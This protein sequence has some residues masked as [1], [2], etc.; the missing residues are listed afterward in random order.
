MRH[1][2]AA[3]AANWFLIVTLAAGAAAQELGKRPEQVPAPTGAPAKANSDPTYQQLRNVGL[4]GE[5]SAANNLVLKRDAGTFT[6]RSGNLYFLAPVNGKVTGAVF[7][8]E[9]SFTLVPPLRMEKNTLSLLTKEPGIT[10]EFNEL[11][12]RFTDATYEEIKKSAGVSAGSPG[13]DAGPL[14]DIQS[15][16]R[17]KLNWNLTAR[18]LQDVLSPEPG[19]FFAAFIKG[20][21]YNGKLL[22]VVD[23]H[24][25][26]YVA[27]E[28][29][30][31]STYDENKFG[32]WAAFHY[33]SEYAAGQASGTQ[34]NAPL[35][36]EDQKLDTM[37][38]KSGKL[39]GT[40]STTF[41]AQAQGLRVVPFDL[42]PTL[43]V[44]SVSDASG[45]PLAFIQEDKD[46][47]PDFAVILPR[48]LAAGERYTL[49]T[50][51]SGKDAVSNEGGG[52]Y[53]PIARSDWYP[54]TAFGDYATYEMTFRIPKGLKMVAT[55]TLDH[56]VQ[57]GDQD[58]SQWHSEVP[59][60]VA[61]FNFGRFKRLEAKL[62]ALGYEVESYANEEEPDIVKSLKHA[63][64][65]DLPAQGS[66][67]MEQY[68]PALGNMSTT[69]DMMKRALGEGQLSVQLYTQF[70]GPAPYKRVAMTQQTAGNYGQ[71][72]PALVYLPITAF[73]DSTTRHELGMDDARGYFKVVGPHEVAHQWWGH[74]VGFNSYRDQWMS[75]GFA[76]LSASLFLQQFYGLK[77]FQKFWE[78]ER[79]LLTQKNKEGYRAID[80]GPVTQGYRLGTSKS[81]FSIPRWLIYP[82]G[83]YI[84]H[85]IRMMMWDSRNPDHDTRFKALMTDFAKTYANRTAST[86]D[87]KAMAEKHMTGEMDLDG[88]GRMD[89]FFDQYVYGTALPA[90]EMNTSFGAGADGSPVLNLKIKQ[91]GVDSQFRMLVPVYLELNNGKV[92]RLGNMR[93]LGNTTVEEH[94]PLS[95]IGL[96]ETPKRALLNYMYDVLCSPDSK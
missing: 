76:E 3:R 28:E 31:L 57:E 20:K 50:V 26:P 59:Q 23:P 41:V 40:A 29:V 63:V 8:G 80:V 79:W 67:R 10:E 32:I 6:F 51:Y 16:L 92:F 33:S 75:E 77:D 19:G 43:R 68:A 74:A 15:A 14:H 53:Y 90:Y 64:Q 17:K 36:I 83:A 72:W 94:V 24:G 27:P 21:K 1:P 54:N 62:P 2:P 69:G 38:E 85:M 7:Q 58:I 56:D 49:R 35:H 84:L 39:N 18:L 96:K 89:W 55:G 91:S 9:G 45:Q 5:S 82:K 61:G 70:F 81:G 30:A 95:A 4:S 22:Y 37:I 65:P 12:L 78:D 25:A 86:E 46:E 93:L 48:A 42:F 44:E 88:N 47:D 87:F 73:F 71:S 60:A 34:K 66:A 52:N 13:G 11:V